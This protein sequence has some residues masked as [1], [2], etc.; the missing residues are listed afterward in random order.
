MS[1]VTIIISRAAAPTGDEA[2]ALEPSYEYAIPIPHGATP[3][4]VAELV[5]K[6]YRRLEGPGE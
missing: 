2:H 3:Q 6:A 5:R 4:D 1:H